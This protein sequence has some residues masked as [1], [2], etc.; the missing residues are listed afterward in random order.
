MPFGLDWS[1]ARVN[2]LTCCMD[3][4]CRYAHRQ[5][6]SP[7]FSCCFEITMAKPGIATDMLKF[8][9]KSW[10]PFHAVREA[11]NLLINARFKHLSEKDS[12]KLKP[13]EKCATGHSRLCPNKC[14][15]TSSLGTSPRLWRSLLEPNTNQAMGLT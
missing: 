7:R 5:S 2:R 14:V 10:T 1:I 3:M 6:A 4:V 12:W 9:N 15:G 13:G 8:I 11:S